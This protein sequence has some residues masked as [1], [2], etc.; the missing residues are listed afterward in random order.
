MRKVKKIS[1]GGA[2]DMIKNVGSKV[3][4]VASAASEKLKCDSEP[5]VI[6]VKDCDGIIEDE[7]KIYNCFH[8]NDIVPV[9][10]VL[11]EKIGWILW[12]T[13]CPDNNFFA[14]M[15]FNG[16]DW[17]DIRFWGIPIPNSPVHFI[18]AGIYIA[19]LW[20]WWVKIVRPRLCKWVIDTEKKK[21]DQ[22]SWYDVSCTSV[23]WM[24][25]AATV[26]SFIGCGD[27]DAAAGSEKIS[28][29]LNTIEGGPACGRK[30]MP[31]LRGGGFLGNWSGA[32]TE[33]KYEYAADY[34]LWKLENERNYDMGD[35]DD[36]CTDYTEC[37]DAFH[38]FGQGDGNAPRKFKEC[39]DLALDYYGKELGNSRFDSNRTPTTSAAGFG[40]SAAG[41]IEEAG[42]GLY[43]GGEAVVN[44]G[45]GA[46]NGLF[47]AL[48]GD[49]PMVEHNHCP[50][51]AVATAKRDGL[52]TEKKCRVAAMNVLRVG[53]NDY[54]S[55]NTINNNLPPT[56]NPNP[57]HPVAD[58]V[59]NSIVEFKRDNEI[60]KET[61]LTTQGEKDLGSPRGDY[62]QGCYPNDDNYDPDK[63][64][65]VFRKGQF[66]E[67]V[68]DSAKKKLQEIHQEVV[69]S[70][71]S[72]TWE[73]IKWFYKQLFTLFII[74]WVIVQIEEST[75]LKI[76]AGIIFI[77]WIWHKM[78]DHC[79][80][81][82][83]SG[84]I[85]RKISPPAS[86]NQ[87]SHA[88]ELDCIAKHPWGDKSPPPPDPAEAARLT[89]RARDLLPDFLK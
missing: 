36:I 77:Y 60:C 19:I 25:L 34:S 7:A 41:D 69:H 14:R 3:A 55:I 73:L 57:N 18:L 16:P 72:T 87:D 54:G 74:L 63:C 38:S 42:S 67:I 75:T 88:K 56:P 12:P 31:A 20:D 46:V 78:I 81:N 24:L 47:S 23:G 66:L 43:C 51:G 44:V 30:Y 83:D 61:S 27:V 48:G 33:P 85:C 2:K 26:K 9:C 10:E 64:L 40:C 89:Q 62:T 71:V 50:G 28:D 45:K 82:N 86:R 37:P 79:N 17:S 4:G 35:I 6:T 68:Y 76:I 1:G 53:C 5:F 58:H 22:C 39:C 65:G 70:P 49:P 29:T 84:Y 52:A 8:A 13:L 15:L 21:E 59:H 11:I 32:G 80:M